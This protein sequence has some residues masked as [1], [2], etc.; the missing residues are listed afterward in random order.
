MLFKV[1]SDNN[2]FRITESLASLGKI[3]KNLEDILANNLSLFLDNYQLMTIHQERKGESG[4]DIIA[5]DYEGNTFLFE[6]KRG[7]ADYSSVGQILTYWSKIAK[8]SYEDL[9]QKAKEYNKKIVEL[10]YDHKMIFNLDNNLRKEDFNKKS[11]LIVV[12]DSSTNKSLLDLVSFL[13]DR[14]KLPIGFVGFESGKLDENGMILH[15]DTSNIDPLL[16][17]ITEEETDLE[18]PDEEGKNYFWYNTD[19]QH[20]DPSELHDRVF[21]LNI[22][23]TYGSMEYGEMLER[24]EV[25]D[26]VF[27]YVTGE[28]M[29]GYGIVTGQWNGKEVNPEK[30]P[31]VIDYWSEYH[32]P[33]D[34]RIKLSKEKAIKPDEIRALG[35]NNFRGTFRRIGSKYKNFIEKLKKRMGQR[36][37][38]T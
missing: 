2:V 30:E 14:F 18:I 13:R 10:D 12:A 1:D 26:E 6:L 20:L 16:D 24:A 36:K 29:R 37:N 34:W 27:A 31:H 4:P 9:N 17:I 38:E 11:G 35:Y 8:A 22:V 32:L 15:F 23:A 25:D 33:V 3:E 21:E 5:L 7:E 28:G 19:K